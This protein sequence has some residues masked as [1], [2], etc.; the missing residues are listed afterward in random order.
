MK[1]EAFDLNVSARTFSSLLTELRL[2]PYCFIFRQSVTPLIFGKS[3]SGSR[4]ALVT[5]VAAYKPTR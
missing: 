2:K 5:V 1:D 4:F 3:L